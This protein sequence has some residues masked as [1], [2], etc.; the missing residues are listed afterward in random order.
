MRLISNSLQWRRKKRHKIYMLQI[1]HLLSGGF[2]GT[3]IINC[4]KILRKFFPK[5]FYLILEE[6]NNS[7]IKL[8][9]I[10]YL[11]LG[12]IPHSKK[13]ASILTTVRIE[14]FRGCPRIYIFY[15]FM[16]HFILIWLCSSSKV[17]RHPSILCQINNT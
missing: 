1:Y 10:F 16:I 5:P 14:L 11:N 4:S 9:K 15:F 13:H 6:K 2:E 8:Q 12:L 7:I 3:L 17:Y